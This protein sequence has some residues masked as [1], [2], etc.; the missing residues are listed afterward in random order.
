MSLNIK[1]FN[2]LNTTTGQM[3]ISGRSPISQ[4]NNILSHITITNNVTNLLPISGTPITIDPSERLYEKAHMCSTSIQIITNNRI[5][6]MTDVIYV[7]SNILRLTYI[8]GMTSAS[9]SL[10][11]A[12]SVKNTDSINDLTWNVVI[13][14]NTSQTV[15]DYFDIPLPN[16]KFYPTL[17]INFILLNGAWNNKIIV[18]DNICSITNLNTLNYCITPVQSQYD[19]NQSHFIVCQGTN[20]HCGIYSRLTIACEDWNM[21]TTDRDYNDLIFSIAD[22]GICDNLLNDINVY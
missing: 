13:A 19:A 12:F 18:R 8:G 15:G 17:F 11:Y 16:K 21:A 1:N 3:S 20:A 10:M 6:G 5:K 4:V 14:K 7:L 9:V 22:V 2:V